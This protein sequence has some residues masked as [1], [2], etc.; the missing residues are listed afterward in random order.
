[1]EFSF[2]QPRPR[3][4]AANNPDQG[5]GSDRLRKAIERN[6][7]KQAK[8]S[9][10]GSTAQVSPAPS[11]DSDWSLPGNGASTAGR[12]SSAAKRSTASAA[13]ARRSVGKADE[14]EFTSEI[15]KSASRAPAPVAYQSKAPAK[16]S[17]SKSVAVKSLGSRGKSTKSKSKKRKINAQANEYIVKGIWVFCA[18]LFVRLIFSDG[19]VQDYYNKKEVLNQRFQEQARIETENKALLKEI[20]L[21]KSNAHYQKK[22]VRDHLGY[23]ASD[24]YLIL[25]PEG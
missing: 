19:G 6:R 2:E 1:M 21:L 10:R 14:Q 18:I 22:V 20:D 24:E 4:T 3:P 8:R 13:T 17:T 7:A 9:T 23:I 15:R 12:R 5:L 16:R 25:F 11:V